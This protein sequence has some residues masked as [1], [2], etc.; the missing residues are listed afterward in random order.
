MA[1]PLSLALAG[2]ARRFA[3]ANLW[4]AV[5]AIEMLAVSGIHLVQTRRHRP[6]HSWTMAGAVAAG[7][8][9]LLAELATQWG[10]LPAT[11]SAGE[12][13]MPVVLV[14]VGTRLFLLFAHA[15][16]DVGAD[17][18]RLA[19]HLEQIESELDQRVETLAQSRAEHISAQRIALYTAQERKRIASDLHD[20]LGAKLL[21][22]VHSSEES[23]VSQLAREALEEMRLSVGGLAGRSAPLG[24]A[25]ADWRAE[26]M[27]RLA[28]AHIEGSWTNPDTDLSITLPSRVFMQ[29]TRILREAISNVI[30][31]SGAHHCE[32]ACRL[33]AGSLVL[34]VSDDGNGFAADLQRGQ[35]MSTMKRRAK[36]IGG[37]CLVESRPGSGVVISLTAPLPAL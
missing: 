26:I 30:R 21:T 34:E 33:D 4:Y 19:D 23:R 7:A 36:A 35:G 31:H 9:I 6:K 2:D 29:L 3:L 22:I 32:V 14:Y 27:T 15:L 5:L 12:I 18:K 37:Q 28:Q 10:L 25:L 13:L 8:A 1:L 24:E 17:R 11:W 16:R 20:D